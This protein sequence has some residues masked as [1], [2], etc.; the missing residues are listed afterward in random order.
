MSVTPPP[1]ITRVKPLGPR[2]LKVMVH[3]D[4]G[5]PFEVMLEALER[6]RLGVGDD[7]PPDRQHNLINDDQDIRVR[8]AAFNLISYSARTR[9]ELKRRL[10]QKGYRPARIDVCLDRLQE[11]GFIDDEAVAAAFVRDRL[12]HRPRGR[13]ALTSELRTKGV[14]GDLAAQTIDRV[15]RAEETDDPD[16]ARSVATKWARRQNEGVLAALASDDRSPEKD[17]ARR[18]LMGYLSRRGFR[19][20]SMGVGVS[21][22]IEEARLRLD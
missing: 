12:R 8:D 5:D 16:L 7:L 22:A 13:A 19:G 1:Y 3:L 9:A 17:K 15:F 20:E 6:N 14:P 11:K 4:R 2:S 21:V 18:R 10:R